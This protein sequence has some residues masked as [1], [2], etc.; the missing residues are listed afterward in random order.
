MAPLPASDC[1]SC[2]R[3]CL[4]GVVVAVDAIVLVK[5]VDTVLP[6]ETDA[7][8]VSEALAVCEAVD[9]FVRVFEVDADV[10]AEVTLEGVAVVVPLLLTVVEAVAVFVL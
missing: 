8:D 6:T 7:V 4:L 1:F 5:L 10:V 9:D 3:S 2:G